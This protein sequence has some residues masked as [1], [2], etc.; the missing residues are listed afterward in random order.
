MVNS[1]FYGL[2]CINILINF[3]LFLFPLLFIFI[4]DAAYIRPTTIQ[5]ARAANILC[6]AL[7]Y[8]SDLDHQELKPVKARK[9]YNALGNMI[10]NNFRL[11]IQLY[12]KTLFLLF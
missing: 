6:A 9:I 4:K 5:T 10:H 11:S 7:Q 2:V 12:G 1:N 3:N 8:R